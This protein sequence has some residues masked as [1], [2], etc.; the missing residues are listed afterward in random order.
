[1]A[2][3]KQNN[4][5]KVNNL[6]K[7]W[8]NKRYFTN[9]L[10]SQVCAVLG[11]Q[12]GDEGKGKL[13]DILAQKYDI[14]A[15]F[16]G[17][18]NAGHTLVV[19][20]KKFAMHLLPCGVL[21]ENTMNV[22]GNGVIVS[23]PTLMDEMQNAL[24]ADI[25]LE[26]RLKISDRAHIVFDFHKAIDGI[27]E[28]K[29][30]KAVKN[31]EK[32]DDNDGNVS[33]GS[34]GTTRRGIGP[35]YASKMYRNGLRMGQLKNWD[36]F[37]K[38]YRLLCQINMDSF[39]FEYNMDEE[40]NRFDK[41]RKIL[42]PMIDDTI[43]YINNEYKNN[44]KILLEGA[45]AALLDI[46]FGTYPMVTASNTTIGAVS[47]GLG[48][49]PSKINTNIGVIKAYTTRVGHGHFPTEQD[50]QIGEHLGNIGHEYGTTTGRSRR[51]GW[52][53]I[54]L[55]RYSNL[56]NGYSSL[57]LTKIDVLDDLDEIKIGVNY[58]LDGKRLPYG[59]M[60]SEI[61]SLSKIDVEYETLPG[62]K[63]DLSKCRSYEELPN[64]A[65]KYISRIEELIGVPVSWIG[66]GP[67]RNDMIGNGFEW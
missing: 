26:N 56:I 7:N 31:D 17:G 10:N 35:C 67:D 33:R 8:N 65:K 54:P 24:N 66:V 15:R 34:I 45:N 55:I 37:E 5:F 19:N 64:N 43:L 60:P 6:I 13:V 42:L 47:T 59:S 48:L 11:S 51:C 23:V 46:D 20:G 61:N 62:W 12:W 36:E 29:R 22:I 39:E 16:N 2:F 4:K 52:L 41:Y 58:L 38:S 53:D 25:P 21:N 3:L 9:G 1:M 27:L 40:L 18:A 30:D 32:I 14:C 63:T 28:E 50:N 44:K 57:N 49:A